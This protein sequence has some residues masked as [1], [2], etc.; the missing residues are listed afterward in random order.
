MRNFLL[1]L[2]ALMIS[3]S[4]N[5]QEKVQMAD[6]LRAEGKIYVVVAVMLVIFL[7][8]AIYLFSIDK[9]VKKLEKDK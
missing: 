4:S 7:S 5:A 6:G 9:R 2:L 1:S 8:V 3:F